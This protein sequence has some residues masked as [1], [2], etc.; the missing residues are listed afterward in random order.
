MFR[1][2]KPINWNVARIAILLT[3]VGGIKTAIG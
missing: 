3:F 2:T 1:L